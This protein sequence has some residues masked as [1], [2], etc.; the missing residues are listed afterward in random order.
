M[1]TGAS[2][3]GTSLTDVFTCGAVAKSGYEKVGFGIDS[4]PQGFQI[5]ANQGSTEITLV[6]PALQFQEYDQTVVP[7]VPIIPSSIVYEYLSCIS[8]VGLYSQD[9]SKQS[10]H[11]NRDYEVAIVYMDEYGRSSTALVDTDNT[12]FVSCDKSIDKNNIRVTLNNYPPFWAKPFICRS[13]HEDRNYPS[14]SS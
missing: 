8:A 10:L 9:S 11:S 12:V 6:I 13:D 3:Q 4:N 5:I 14:G 7:P 1:D 2:E